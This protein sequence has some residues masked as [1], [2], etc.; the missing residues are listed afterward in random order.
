MTTR[1]A[2]NVVGYVDDSTDKYTKHQ[3]F[4]MFN[5][6][7][8]KDL[9]KPIDVVEIIIQETATDYHIDKEDVTRRRLSQY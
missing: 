5:R 4:E 7:A 1:W 2:I 9:F 3:L 6:L 8:M